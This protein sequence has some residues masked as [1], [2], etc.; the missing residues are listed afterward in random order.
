MLSKKGLLTLMRS[1]LG[2]YFQIMHLFCSTSVHNLLWKKEGKKCFD[3]RT[4]GQGIHIVHISSK[5]ASSQSSKKAGIERCGRVL[6]S[7]NR[8][9]FGNLTRC[10]GQKQK[11]LEELMN[12]SNFKHHKIESC[13][14][15]LSKLLNREE[16][17][18]KLKYLLMIM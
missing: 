2:A 6:S 8:E 1:I 5:N 17:M 16:I 4:C 13:R 12:G 7:W 10:I 11:E 18:W 9:V 15:E 14:K 3:L